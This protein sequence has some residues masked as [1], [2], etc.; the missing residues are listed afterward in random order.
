MHPEHYEKLLHDNITEDYKKAPQK[1]GKSINLE[2]KCIA[3]PFER[4]NRVNC[5]AQMP[6]YVSLK[7]HKENFRSNPSCRLINPSKNELGKVSKR[8]L[9]EIN[10]QLLKTLKLN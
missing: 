3:K 10:D 6:A 4:S 5:L 2:S 8:F 7:D 1:L 9:E